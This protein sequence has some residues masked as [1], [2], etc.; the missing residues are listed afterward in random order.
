MLAE[1]KFAS[2]LSFTFLYKYFFTPYLPNCNPKHFAMNDKSA[3]AL[4]S[5]GTH[6]FE[7]MS[8]RFLGAPPQVS[9]GSS[10]GVVLSRWQAIIWSNAG[11]VS[12]NNMSDVLNDLV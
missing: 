9:I 4:V 1:I 2:W 3:F 5:D 11:W 8:I 6:L 12:S 7:P 10:S